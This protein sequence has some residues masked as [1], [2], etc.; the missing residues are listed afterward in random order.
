MSDKP[1][2]TRSTDS[3]GPGG[4]S[5]TGSSPREPRR[6]G[7]LVPGVTFLIGLVLGGVVIFAQQSGRDSAATEGKSTPSATATT[8]APS[9]AGTADAVVRVP[10][11]CLRV[12]DDSKAL[13][14][15]ASKAVG[16]ARDLDAAALAD[17]VRQLDTAQKAVTS[18]ADAC[19]AVQASLPT[20][21]AG[22]TGNTSDAGPSAS[23]TTGP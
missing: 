4:T 9:G 17:A 2:T 10:A 6:W 8:T 1:S 19:R 13:V 12:A 15:I 23:T 20:V 21:S 5:S 18:S 14:D 16:A 11:A 22:D 7:W 3:E